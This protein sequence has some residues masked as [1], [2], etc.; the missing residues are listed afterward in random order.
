MGF[1]SFLRQISG[2]KTKGSNSF[3]TSKADLVA[4]KF[5]FT[6][7]ITEKIQFTN[8]KEI[9]NTITTI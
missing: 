7:I 1:E 5:K 2:L 6:N 4:I 3:D 9:V 8:T